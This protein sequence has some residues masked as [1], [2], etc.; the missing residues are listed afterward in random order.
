R[1]G[2]QAAGGDAAANSRRSA[3]SIPG[4]KIPALPRSNGAPAPCRRSW[5]G[6][7]SKDISIVKT[8]GA[9]A[10]EAWFQRSLTDTA[11]NAVECDPF[12]ESAATPPGLIGPIAAVTVGE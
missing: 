2:G 10:R 12:S 4:P 7:P 11:L 1:P 3:S 6:I 9:T 5:H 8:G